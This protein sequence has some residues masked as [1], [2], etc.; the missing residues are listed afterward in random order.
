MF[1]VDMNGTVAGWLNTNGDCCVSAIVAGIIGD[2]G[3]ELWCDI[4]ELAT[5]GF[6]GDS[7]LGDCCGWNPG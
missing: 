4:G 5:G 3:L 7:S 2:V 1:A 6:T